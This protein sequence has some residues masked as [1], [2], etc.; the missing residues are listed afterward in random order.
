MSFSSEVKAELCRQ[1]FAR[2][3]CVQAEACGVLLYCNRFTPTEVKIITESVPFAQ[4]LPGLFHRAF[5]LSF[6]GLGD[7][8]SPKRVFSI[9]DPEKLALLWDACAFDPS[10]P[11]HHINFGLLEERHC[12]LSFLRGAFLAG[13]SVTDPVKGYHLELTTSH[14]HVSRELTALL[15]ELGYVSKETARK[16]N[17][18]TYFKQSETIEELLTAIGAP[19][20]AMELMNAK[21]EKHLRNGVNRRVNC[22]AANLDKTVD[23]A[24][25][26]R[27]AIRLLRESGR[28]KKL[29]PKLQEAARL[30]EKYPELSLSQLAEQCDPPVSKSS[31]SHRLRRLIELS[32]EAEQEQREAAPSPDGE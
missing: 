6:D 7:P 9:S 29:T 18:V 4:R 15:R 22:E 11:A 20:S 31:L 14:G 19:L 3:C 2:K 16:S 32:R 26:Q 1:K 13:G 28:L 24:T 23:A 27:Q 21:A 10:G 25:E 5:G 30:R 17:H 12:R 8:T